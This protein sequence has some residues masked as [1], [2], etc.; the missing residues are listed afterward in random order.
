MMGLWVLYTSSAHVWELVA[1]GAAAVLA[2]IATAIVEEQRF[3]QFAPDARWLIYFFML[4]WF[5]L[6][7]TALVY[8]AAMKYALKQ[9]S[10]GYLIA[11]D[12]DSGGDDARSS[13]RR[14]LVTTLTTVPPNSVV[15]GIDRTNNKILL[16]MLA[17]DDVPWF[18]KQLGG[19]A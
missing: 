8:R 15:I 5:V 17:P 10:D 6:R 16:H 2:T 4:P 14:S 11:L 19:H 7:D 13:A 1:G 3:A 12:F 9:K 18:V